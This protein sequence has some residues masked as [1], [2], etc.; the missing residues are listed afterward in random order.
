MQGRRRLFYYIKGVAYFRSGRFEE[1][2]KFLGVQLKLTPGHSPSYY[3]I[4]R[5]LFLMKNYAQA[6]CYF[7]VCYDNSRENLFYNYYLGRS[8]LHLGEL[9]RALTHLKMA[10]SRLKGALF[11]SA[12]AFYRMNDYKR[13]LKLIEAL[14]EHFYKRREVIIIYSAI[15]FNLG[16]QYYNMGELEDASRC[17][18]RSIELNKN[19]YPSYFQMGS[20]SFE[21]GEYER[22]ISYL[23]FIYPKFRDNEALNL[24]LAYLYNLTSRYE[25][26]EELL[27]VGDLNI[28]ALGAVKFKKILALTLYRNGKYKEA[29][30]IFL[31]LYKS[32]N[33]DENLLYHLAQARFFTG[34]SRRALNCYELIFKMTRSNLTINNSY[35]FLLIRLNSYRKAQEEAFS[36]I[37]ERSYDNKTVLFYYYS[38]VFNNK[39][40][41]FDSLYRRLEGRY[42]NNT[43]FLE[44]TARYYLDRGDRERAI[45]TYYKLYSLLPEDEHTLKELVELFLTRGLFNQ[46][47]YYLEKMYNLN[48]DN[49][50]VIYYYAY[51]LI[52][53]GYNEQA[54]EVLE[55]FNEN[56]SALYLLL[57]EAYIRKKERKKGYSYLKKSF[58]LDPLY[59]PVQYKTILFFYKV[60]KYRRALNICEIMGRSNSS[61]RRHLLYQSLIMAK[62]RDYRAAQL[63]LK[64]YISGEER[65]SAFLLTILAALY[66]KSGRF[67]TALALLAKLMRKS[68]ESGPRLVLRALCQRKLYDLEGLKRSERLLA[69][70]F[71][72]SPIYK[73]YYEQFYGDKSSLDRRDLGLRLP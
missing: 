43:V 24:S 15:L 50:T 66:Y 68:G 33:Y 8:L 30:P 1:A 58:L 47:I 59:L 39:I 69:G 13:S 20:L 57:S 52:K 34:D 61:F 17:F 12:L 29:I 38:S 48:P 64:S 27:K 21:R 16:N 40:S 70:N 67:K 7:K 55:R 62:I 45:S 2:L 28:S 46:A 18:V 63:K 10:G 42:L 31:S 11:Y 9:E 54:I 36:F 60:G 71:N 32:K 5:T 19:A 44:A 14:P 3:Y 65:K 26:L 6:C 49:G 53:G 56:S 23:E 35:L 41:N 37:K 51:F 25:R 4:G 73:E 22:A 72:C